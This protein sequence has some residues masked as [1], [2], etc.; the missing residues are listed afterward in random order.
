[1]DAIKLLRDAGADVL[2]EDHRG[3]TPMSGLQS[4]VQMSPD[5]TDKEI[6][7]A[8]ELL[9]E[10]EAEASVRKQAGWTYS[11]LMKRYAVGTNL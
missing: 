5:A 6:A 4:W 3:R 7:D 8:L 2:A 9:K 1:M 11:I 10:M